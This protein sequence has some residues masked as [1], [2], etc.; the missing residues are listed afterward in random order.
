[1]TASNAAVLTGKLL[2]LSSGAIYADDGSVI[3]LHD[4]KLDAL[5]DIIEGMNGK[6]L[7]VAY[8]FKHDY[9]RIAG[10]LTKLGIAFERLDSEASMRRW[11]AEQIQHAGNRRQSRQRQCG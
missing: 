6:P 5:E 9:D 4:R 8:W 1:M 7:L 3:H 11:N 2:Q 10:R